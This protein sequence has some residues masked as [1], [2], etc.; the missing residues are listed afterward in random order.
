MRV[1]SA[2]ADTHSASLAAELFQDAAVIDDEASITLDEEVCKRHAGK[3]CTIYHARSTDITTVNVVDLVRD[4]LAKRSARRRRKRIRDTGALRRAALS[5]SQQLRSET[6]ACVARC[7]PSAACA[8]A[9]PAHSDLIPPLSRTLSVSPPRQSSRHNSHVTK[10]ARRDGDTAPSWYHVSADAS[11]H[12]G[13]N[14]AILL[15]QQHQMMLAVQQAGAMVSGMRAVGNGSF[16]APAFEAPSFNPHMLAQQQQQQQQQQ[17]LG[18][19]QNLANSRTQGMPGTPGAPGMP[20]YHNMLSMQAMQAAASGMRQLGA[21]GSCARMGSQP[22]GPH[23]QVQQ[24][25]QPQQQQQQL[26]PPQQQHLHQQQHQQGKHQQE[27]QNPSTRPT[28]SLV[29]QEQEHEQQH[30]HQQLAQQLYPRDYGSVAYNGAWLPSGFAGFRWAD[31]KEPAWVNGMGRWGEGLMPPQQQQQRIQQQLQM[32]MQIQLQQQQQQQQ[33]QQQQQQQHRRQMT[34]HMGGSEPQMQIAPS[35]VVSPPQQQQHQSQAAAPLAQKKGGAINQEVQA[36]V[37]AHIAAQVELRVQAAQGHVQARVHAQLQ[38]QANVNAAAMG[39]PRHHQVFEAG[40][41]AHFA[42]QAAVVQT[43]TR[44]LQQ[45]Q[46]VAATVLSALPPAPSGGG[47]GSGS[48]DSFS[49]LLT[50]SAA[51][52]YA[53]APGASA[54]AGQIEP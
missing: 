53:G 10:H 29:P 41:G 52:L 35:G 13:A 5:S 45:P 14:N 31:K 8:T 37:Q 51:K 1:G 16:A 7:C 50:A 4:V 33:R 49:A 15:A 24:P 39:M 25:Q 12:N 32:Q 36:H 40:S 9:R 44:D 21:V 54:V 23:Q 19:F 22:S 20:G 34:A 17:Q 46:S 43:A 2:F 27:P 38:A 42:P 26:P 47:G 3:V 48:F 18:A 30:Q 6:S 28:P 11:A